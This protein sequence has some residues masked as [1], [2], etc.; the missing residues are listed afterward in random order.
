MT[1]LDDL[2]SRRRVLEKKVAEIEARN[3]L[4]ASELKK[5]EKELKEKTGLDDLGKLEVYLEKLETEIDSR[6]SKLR[7]SLSEVESQLV[8]VLSP[9]ESTGLPNSYT[10]TKEL[11]DGI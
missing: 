4:N 1:E 10:K 11:L 9:D 2:L 3:K 7:E 8:D 5:L 6:M